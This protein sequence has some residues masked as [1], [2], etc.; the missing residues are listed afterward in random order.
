MR[1]LFGAVC[2]VVAVVML[3]AGETK[4]AEGDNLVRFVGY[5]IICFVLAGL[6]MAAAILDLSAVRREAR[7]E[8]RKLLE[9][10]L[11]DI[12]AEKMRR[13]KTKGGSQTDGLKH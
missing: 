12:E 3:L 13:A 2:L 10:T 11:L 8:Q 5:W 6:A 1:R 9:H 7:A 4:P